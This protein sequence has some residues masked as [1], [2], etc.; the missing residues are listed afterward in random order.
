MSIQLN[1][2]WLKWAVEIE[3]EAGCDIQ[4]GLNLGQDSRE[5]LA[6][7]QGYINH[8]QLMLILQEE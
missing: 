3:D 5:Y 1:D 2:D 6:K 7:R 8:E 4:A